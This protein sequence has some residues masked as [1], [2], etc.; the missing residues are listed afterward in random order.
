MTEM[1]SFKD[2][3]RGTATAPVRSQI[4]AAR[5]IAKGIKK[6]RA[7]EL[8]TKSCNAKGRRAAVEI[9]RKLLL[10]FP[11][12]QEDDIRVTPSGVQGEDLQLSPRARE[13]L[14]FAFE[15]KNKERLN[16]WDALAQSKAHVKDSKHKPVVVFRRNRTPF[17]VCI[18][19]DTFL[20]LLKEGKRDECRAG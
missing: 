2:L 17:H 15:A 5:T 9:Q 4:E 13:L 1:F 18:E 7:S 10:T 20:E 16:I 19:L 6:W 14:P 8:K 3:Q 12:L 11:E